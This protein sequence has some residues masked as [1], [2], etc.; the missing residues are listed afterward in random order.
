VILLDTNVLSEALRPAPEPRVIAWL[1]RRFPECSIS[2]ITSFELRAG[3]ELL[4]QGRR[5][6]TLE[7]AV[8]R[9]IRR[10]AGRVYAFDAASAEAAARLLGS[11]RAAGLGLHQVRTKLADLQIA[12]IAA[13]YGLDLAT[14]NVG[15]FQG[16]GLSLIDP[17][18]A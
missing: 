5:R 11:A 12:G 13:A 3:I 8:V 17:W 10:F 16:V 2:T 15:D 7:Q 1:D 4:D 14:R 18:T 6:D 9:M